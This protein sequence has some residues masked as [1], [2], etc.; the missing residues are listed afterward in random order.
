[1]LQ[2]TYSEKFLKH[3]K[4]LTTIEKE[5]FIN[6]LKIFEGDQF[7]PSLRVKKIK[8]TNNIF[9]FSINMDLRVAWS[10]IDDSTIAL[11]DIGLHDILNKF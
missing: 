2:I 6:K 8:G 4:K 11:I 1:M 7:Y 9:E 5:Q 10:Y 3:Y